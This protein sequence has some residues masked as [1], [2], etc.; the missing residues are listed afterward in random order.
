MQLRTGKLRYTLQEV[1]C[2]Q[3]P[4][5]ICEM[6]FRFMTY[7]N[8]HMIHAFFRCEPNSKA[9][10]LG[11]KV[12]LLA[13]SA[14][15]FSSVSACQGPTVTILPNVLTN[16]AGVITITSPT[17]VPNPAAQNPTGVSSLLGGGFA[18]I[19]SQPLAAAAAASA[20][21]SVRKAVTLTK[22]NDLK[23]NVKQIEQDANNV[24]DQIDNEIEEDPCFHALSSKF[25]ARMLGKAGSTKVVAHAAGDTCELPQEEDAAQAEEDLEALTE[26]E[27][28]SEAAIE[29]AEEAAEVAAD[30]CVRR[31]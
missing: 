17:V 15:L 10:T 28:A 30:A 2:L 19:L 29:A 12:A 18:S 23:A 11:R 24:K 9:G 14:A 6:A 8:L 16:Q 3:V 26:S 5:R 25:V 22:A 27:E 4:V 7:D 20:L 21:L 31:Q 13:F 1:H